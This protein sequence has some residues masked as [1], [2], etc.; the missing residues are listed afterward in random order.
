M[1]DRK[2]LRKGTATE[3]EHVKPGWTSQ[4]KQR[5]AERI[6]KAH[7]REY[8]SYYIVLPGAEQRMQAIDRSM[9]SR[10]R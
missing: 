2:Q 4:H 5:F 3:M 6:A 7:L 10:R 1:Y 8:K 9:K